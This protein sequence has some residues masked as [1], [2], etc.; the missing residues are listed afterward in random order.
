MKLFIILIIFIISATSNAQTYRDTLA[1]KIINNYS[2]DKA[3]YDE[4]KKNI[5]E[6]EKIEN[7]FN[8]EILFK[9]LEFMYQQNDLEYFKQSLILLTE[10]YGYNVS[11]LSGRENYYEDIMYGNLSDWFKK[12]YIHKHSIWLSENLDKQV[13]IYILNSLSQR[14]QIAHKMLKNVENYLDLDDNQKSKIKELDGAV[15]SSNIKELEHISSQ[16]GSLPTGNSFALIQKPYDIIEWHGFQHEDLFYNTFNSLY[17]YYKESYMN[18][19]ISSIRFKNIDSFLFMNKG[20]QIFDLLKVDNIPD[21]LLENKNS[22]P[23][24]NLEQTNKL[25]KELKWY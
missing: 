4:L 5:N 16:I 9:N 20:T 2:K 23:L 6:L 3:S 14:D 10:K 1:A 22:I 12:N 7:K 21:G 19:D 15:F 25:K 13:D 17:P 24:D 11:Y 18:M 8:P